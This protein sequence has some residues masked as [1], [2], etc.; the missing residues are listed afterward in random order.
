MTTDDR[1]NAVA[2][3]VAAL[4]VVEIL[5]GLAPEVLA[6]LAARCRWRRHAA[7]A[8]LIDRDELG[9][10]VLLLIEGTARVLDTGPDGREVTYDV[11]E[12]GAVLGE[13]AALDGGGRSA[14]VV[15]LTDGLSAALPASAFRELLRAQPEVALGLLRRLAR[16]LRFADLKITELATMGAVQ[17]IARHLL[18]LPSRFEAGGLVVEP[19]PTQDAIAAATGTTRETVGRIMVQLRQAGVFA[20]RGRALLVP[21]PGK[22]QALAGLDEATSGTMM[23][24][25]NDRP[26]PH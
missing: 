7:G 22:L 2:D 5:A 6:Q 4:G 23:N 21:T 26:Q 1:D 10:D 19:L 25:A 14:S 13:L 3:P 11:V 15:A 20:R 8:M 18:R 16:S 24:R 17:R 12:T 9:G